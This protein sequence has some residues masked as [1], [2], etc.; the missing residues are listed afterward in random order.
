MEKVLLRIVE[1]LTFVAVVT[2]GL[3]MFEEITKQL[4]G[5]MVENEEEMVE[6]GEELVE[7]L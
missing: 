5:D 6:N 3:E 4:E 7:F 2:F 1:S